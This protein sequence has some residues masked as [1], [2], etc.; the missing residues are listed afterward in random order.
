MKS[1]GAWISKKFVQKTNQPGEADDGPSPVDDF[2]EEQKQD[3][4]AYGG[5][6]SAQTREGRFSARGERPPGGRDSMKQA[7]RKANHNDRRRTEANPLSQSHHMALTG[8]NRQSTLSSIKST[9]MSTQQSSQSPVK[10]ARNTNSITLSSQGGQE[11]EYLPGE[12]PADFHR[13]V[14][15]LEIKIEMHG[16][17]QGQ[18]DNEG[19]IRLLSDLMQLYSVSL[20]NTPSFVRA[21]ILHFLSLATLD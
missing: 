12:L 21:C 17:S 20:T 13:K 10:K 7:T 18:Q 2:L 14:V 4:T 19:Q 11:L 5:S 6:G 1:F 8:A 3:F 16:V 9:G 15:D